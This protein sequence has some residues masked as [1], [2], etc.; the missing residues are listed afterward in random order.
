MLLRELQLGKR[1]ITNNFIE[2]I[3]KEFN[4]AD[5]VKISILKS[6]RT[7]TMDEIA[8]KILS[9]LGSKFII[10]ILGFKIII[11]KKRR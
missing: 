7:E 11:K 10:R 8:Q 5:I 4:K 3:K 2:S 6:A 1:G 9:K